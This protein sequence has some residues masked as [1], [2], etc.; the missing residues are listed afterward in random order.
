MS[1]T[2]SFYE[3]GKGSIQGTAA[4]GTGAVTTQTKHVGVVP[5]K[6]L[7]KSIRCYGQAGPTATSL[8][9]QV[10]ARTSAGATGNALCSAVSIDFADAAA[11]KKGTAATLSTT[12]S[13]LHLDQNQLIEVVVTADTC[14]AGPGD[15]T[16][17]IEFAPEV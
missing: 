14:S 9:A 13:Y 15:L 4:L 12:T 10:Y 17:V 3:G 8:T 16:T 1:G 2:N 7:V 6:C 11:A 5:K